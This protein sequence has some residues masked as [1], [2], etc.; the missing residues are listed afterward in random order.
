M[1]VP[2]GSVILNKTGHIYFIT[3]FLLKI[4]KRMIGKNPTKLSGI[5]FLRD[6]CDKNL[7]IY[8][9]VH[10]YSKE[11]NYFARKC[12]RDWHFWGRR[13]RKRRWIVRD[14]HGVFVKNV[15]YKKVYLWRRN[16]CPILNATAVFP[17][18]TNNRYHSFKCISILHLIKRL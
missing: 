9:K 13:P 17:T 4:L 16:K 15:Y 8:V 3:Q 1:Y 7:S 12:A 18:E 5:S 11:N 2:I 10:E 14:L 6:R